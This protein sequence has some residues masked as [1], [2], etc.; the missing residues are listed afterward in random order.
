LLG[1]PAV[2]DEALQAPLRSII[3]RLP[4]QLTHRSM[5]RALTPHPTQTLCPDER[6]RLQQLNRD[7]T[8]LG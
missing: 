4:Q 1:A 5:P 8:R 3:A 7:I 2:G 6:E